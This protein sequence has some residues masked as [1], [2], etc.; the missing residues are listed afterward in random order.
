MH[1]QISWKSLHYLATA[2]VRGVGVRDGLNLTGG[3]VI[4]R[5]FKKKRH[6]FSVTLQKSGL[7]TKVLSFEPDMATLLL[8]DVMGFLWQLFQFGCQILYNGLS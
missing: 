6:I 8:V 7:T 5:F 2:G 4:G 3:N 1:R